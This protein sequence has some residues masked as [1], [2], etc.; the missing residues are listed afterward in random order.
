MS[1]RS[2]PAETQ[3][4]AT[5]P[6]RGSLVSIKI[7]VWIAL[8]LGR[9]LAQCFLY[10]I[11]LYF[12]LSSPAALRASRDYLGRALG[13]RSGWR[14]SYRH[15]LAFGTCVLDRVFLLNE[16]DQWFEITVTGDDLL[17]QIDQQSGGCLLFGAHFGSF[18]AARTIR[19]RYRELPVSLLM[20]E[21]NA[22]KI[23][24][25]L[26]AINPRLETEVIGLGRLD[27]LI[28]VAERL[29][30]G[31]F[32]GVLA[33]RNSDG[34]DMVQLPFLGAQAA[35]PQGPFKV[36]MMLGRPVVMMAGIYKGKGRYEVRF[37]LLAQARESR[38]AD[39]KAWMDEI[40][41][42][43]A[44]KLEALCKEYPYNWFNFYDFWA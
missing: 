24:A 28:A 16:Q 22:K 14:D 40:M 3:E 2:T 17:R 21:E 19:R 25:A 8:R 37:E 6:E 13:R 5:R 11:C 12:L 7:C 15:F 33:D 44:T 41:R 34:R 43:Y 36:A 1:S 32:V 39:P 23:R 4:W 18:E 30:A 42:L 20:Y 9:R 31:H 29:R 35:F 10:P 26:G 38:P 27:S